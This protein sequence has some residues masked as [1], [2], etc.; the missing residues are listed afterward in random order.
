MEHEAKDEIGRIARKVLEIDSLE[1]CG[2][3]GNDYHLRPV[4]AIKEALSQAFEAGR[5]AER[6][7]NKKQN[8]NDKKPKP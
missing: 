3:D 1:M 8:D 6:L 2:K 7:E 5:L 4:D